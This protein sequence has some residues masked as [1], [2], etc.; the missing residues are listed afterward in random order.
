MITQYGEIWHNNKIATKQRLSLK[1]RQQYHKKH[2]LPIMEEL[3]TWCKTQKASPE[4][5]GN[6]GLGK[7]IKY[8]LKHYSRLTTFCHI[9]GA[10]IDNNLVEMTLK[11]ISRSRKNSYFFKSLAG[12]KVADVATS[13]IATC[14]LN[15]INIFDYLVSVQQNRW[16]VSQNPERWLPWT[17]EQNRM[18]SKSAAA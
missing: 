8:F 17:F 10:P 3:K 14:E 13:L 7:A 11:L 18:K 16:Q 15:G 4:Y 1:Y 9:P 5:E 2:S 12:A 6:S